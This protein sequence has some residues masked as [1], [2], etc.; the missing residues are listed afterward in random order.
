V[1]H[2]SLASQWP[3]RLS[4]GRPVV[5]ELE[6]ELELGEPLLVGHSIDDGRLCRT[7]PRTPAV[8]WCA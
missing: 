3:R 6:L 1:T 2:A 5:A 7:P 4:D 8:H